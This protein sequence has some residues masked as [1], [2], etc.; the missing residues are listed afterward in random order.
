MGRDLT[1]IC[2]VLFVLVGLL[3][4]RRQR[5]VWAAVALSAAVLS[6]ETAFVVVGG[7]AFAGVIAFVRGRDRPGQTDV[8][9]LLPALAYVGWEF[10]GWSLY[11]A[12]PLRTD[13]TNN[14]TAPF[15]SAAV[16]MWQ[17]VGLL[18]SEHAVIWWAELAGRALVA[19]SAGTVLRRSRA[20]A[21]EKWAWVFA[22]ALC[23]SLSRALWLSHADFRGFEDLYVLSVVLLLDS[24]RDFE[25]RRCRDRCPLGRDVRTS[26][27]CLLTPSSTGCSHPRSHRSS[28]GRRGHFDGVGRSWLTRTGSWYGRLSVPVPGSDPARLVDLERYPVTTQQ[29]N[30][31]AGV[32]AE[33]RRQLLARGAAEI[34]GFLSPAG[35]AELVRDA[36]A[37]APR[38]HASGGQGTAYL[39]FPD[40]ALP[41]DHPRL[42]FADY[43]VRAVA[44]DVTPLHSPLRCLYEWDP[45]KDLI[46]AALDRGPIFRYA[47]P[48][49]AL[50]LAVMGEGDQLQW[51]FDQTDFV[52]SLAI[53]PAEAGG[54]FEVVPRLRSVEDERYD[55]VAAVLS[56]DRSRVETLPMTPGTLLIFEGRHSLHRVSPIVGGR[57]RHVGLLA[58]DTKPGTMGSDLLRA[59]RYG[60]TEALDVPPETWP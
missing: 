1:E 26:D 56:G 32:V 34:P 36:D 10:V 49:G 50:N 46:E 47:D 6:R 53:Q 29:S 20:P 57:W 35:V 40:F 21:H 28:G 58:Y 17:Y 5:S 59:D 2:E 23:I 18:P 37:L 13:S 19:V 60:R 9:W 54:D 22:A 7:L 48:F 41:P 11:G 39:E 43:A 16:A 44:Y 4:L 30:A 45:L 31:Y 38:A 27:D 42:H 8:A 24:E 25:V 51:H 3:L 15:E 12:I 33:G 55:Q 14:I 52:V